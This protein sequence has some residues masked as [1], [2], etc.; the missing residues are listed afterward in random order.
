MLL[1]GIMARLYHVW[2]A[3][4]FWIPSQRSA[5][6][7]QSALSSASITGI[8]SVA[9]RSHSNKS[10]SFLIADVGKSLSFRYWTSCGL[11]NPLK[12]IFIL[13]KA[14]TLLK[15]RPLEILPHSLALFSLFPRD[16]R[17]SRGFFAW[18]DAVSV[19]NLH[20]VCI[21]YIAVRPYKSK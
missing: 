10:S 2:L 8:F 7:L 12:S 6:T 17:E 9:T 5:S 11:V 16:S 1:I 20:N 18:L 19:K 15:C 3:F 21:L 13:V 14:L 4:T